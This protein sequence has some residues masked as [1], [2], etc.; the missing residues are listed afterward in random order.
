MG[1]YSRIPEQRV[2]DALARHYV[3]VRMQ[4]GVP[5]LDSDWNELEGIRKQE[6]Q[7]FLKWFVGNGVPEGNKGFEIRAIPLTDNDFLI[8]GGDGTVEGAGRCL[9]DGLDARNEGDLRYSEQPLFGTPALAVAWGVPVLDPIAVPVA[10]GPVLAYL[11]VWEREVT[12]V[13]DEPHLVHPL[14][15]VETCVRMRRE[16]V[17]RVR[18]GASEPVLGDP[19][20]VMGHRY[21]ALAA[22][23]R[24]AGDGSIHAEDVRDLRERQLLIPP[25]TL[26]SDVLGVPAARYRRGEGRPAVSLRDAINALLRGELPASPP[27]PLAAGAGNNEASNSVVEDARQELWA[28][29]T[30]TRNGNRDLFVRRYSGVAR[31]WREEEAVTLDPSD[32]LD[33]ISLRDST[34]DIWLLWHT[35]RGAASQHLWMKRYRVSSASWDP[36]TELVA[37]AA[38]HF[39]HTLVEDANTN[40]R[41]FWTA[42]TAG[43]PAIMTKRYTRAADAWSVD[44]QLINSAGRDEEP[45]AVVDASGTVFLVWR[46]TRDGVEQAYFNRYDASSLPLGAE[47]RVAPAANSQ[48]DARFLVDSRDVVHAFWRERVSASGPWQLRHVRFD[49]ATSSWPSVTTFAL[50]ASSD[51]DPTAVEDILGNVW[52]FWRSVRLGGEVLLYRIFNVATDSWS[53]ERPVTEVPANYSLGAVLASASGGVWVFWNRIEGTSTQAYQRQFFPVI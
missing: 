53:D 40:I 29:F 22:I 42:F 32:D 6:V 20:Y 35:D 19:D 38:Q 50:N 48:R 14:I 36:D 3:S 8:R 43:E 21:Y 16:W 39:Q 15:G 24:R 44:Q 37:S 9:V 12:A 13:E 2:T 41:V 4:Q 49:R 47:T 5:I 11:D 45:H 18:E 31:T 23:E 7:A 28:F 30:S 33:P 52:M 25:A 27:A 34:G 26:V 10:S 46:S 51:F 1:D 17:V